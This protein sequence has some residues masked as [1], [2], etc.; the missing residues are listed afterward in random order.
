[1]HHK[2]LRDNQLINRSTVKDLMVLV[3]NK[4]AVNQQCALA[5]KWPTGYRAALGRTLPSGQGR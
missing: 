1:M 5:A 3:D 4:L 2:R